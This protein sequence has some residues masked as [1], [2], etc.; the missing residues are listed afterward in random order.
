MKK[1]KEEKDVVK[2]GVKR[3]KL[4]ARDYK[5]DL[6]SQVGKSVVVAKNAPLD[7]SGG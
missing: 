4:K 1:E 3:E 2:K 6:D 5:I 7:Q